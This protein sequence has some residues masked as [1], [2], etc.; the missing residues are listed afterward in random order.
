MRMK[1]NAKFK[2]MKIICNLVIICNLQV[3]VQLLFER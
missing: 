2:V 1:I 3:A